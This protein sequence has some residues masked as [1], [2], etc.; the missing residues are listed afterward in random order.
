MP[1]ELVFLLLIYMIHGELQHS[2]RDTSSG[3]L[4]KERTQAR[5]RPASRDQVIETGYTA[6][7]RL[8]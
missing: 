6:K 2:L 3:Y 8:P 4:R 5:L 7:P 1:K